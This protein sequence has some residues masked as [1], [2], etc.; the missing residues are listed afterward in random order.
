[1]VS[2]SMSLPSKV[3]VTQVLR[4][5]TQYLSSSSI[6]PKPPVERG[7]RPTAS[8]RPTLDTGRRDHEADSSRTVPYDSLFSRPQL[9]PRQ[10]AV[11]RAVLVPQTTLAGTVRFGRK[12]LDRYAAEG[13]V[14]PIFLLDESPYPRVQDPTSRP[15]V[16]AVLFLAD[17][18][19]AAH[20]SHSR[21]M[22]GEDTIPR[23]YLA[24]EGAEAGAARC[25]MGFRN[26][27]SAW[28]SSGAAGG[29]WES[30]RGVMLPIAE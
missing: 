6:G 2:P 20:A 18:G 27:R 8:Q 21:T 17:V 11:S 30:G 15:I 13:Q 1:M 3:I 12:C 16:P 24:S 9:F 19:C 5:E 28:V 22:F 23:S 29:L 25:G 7:V 10:L 14:P 26:V 4:Y